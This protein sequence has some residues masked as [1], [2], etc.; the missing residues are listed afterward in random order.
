MDAATFDVVRV[1]FLDV[2]VADAAFLEV[3]K[4][5]DGRRLLSSLDAILETMHGEDGLP[6][7]SFRV[8]IQGNLSDDLIFPWLLV[9]IGV[10]DD[11]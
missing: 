6:M 9:C 5:V 4:L 3:D 1:F 7:T 2:D 10:D 11:R 8:D